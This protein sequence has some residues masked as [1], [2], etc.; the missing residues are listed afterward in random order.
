MNKFLFSNRAWFCLLGLLASFTG[1][2]QDFSGRP[3][4]SIAY[5]PAGQ[6]IDPRDLERM[7][8]VQVGQPLDPKQVAATMDRLFSTGLYDDLQVDAEPAGEGVAI[9]FLTQPRRFIGHVGA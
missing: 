5:E 8:L 3:V 1:R 4:A 7:Q 2:A 6:P 9:K